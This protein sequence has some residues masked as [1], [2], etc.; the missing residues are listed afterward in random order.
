MSNTAVALMMMPIAMAVVHR[1]GQS[2]PGQAAERLSTALV[3]A[4]AFGASIGGIGT[5]VGSPPN[6]IFMEQYAKAFPNGPAIT[7]LSWTLLCTPL[8][9]VLL[10]LAWAS[11]YFPL[12]RGSELRGGAL[13]LSEDEHRLPRISGEEVK[14]LLV[15]VGAVL[16]WLFRSP[17]HL[18]TFTVPGWGSWFTGRGTASLVDDGTVAV[19]ATILLFI[20]PAGAKAGGGPLLRW[21]D[22]ERLPWGTMLL[23][24]GGFALAEGLQSSGLSAWI[25][26][27]LA[28][29]ASLPPLL[30]LV[31][32]Y[33]ST[34]AFG[35]LASNTAV[36]QVLLPIAASISETAR[37]SPALL[38][39][40][41]AIAASLDFLLPAATP[42]NAIAV[43]TGKVSPRQLLMYGL[44]IEIVSAFVTAAAMFWLAPY[45]LA[46]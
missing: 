45:V 23:F 7:F 22:L 10:L 20:L 5:P 25:G 33:M 12:G 38:M 46:L 24:G 36:A 39:I 42:P 41:V 2:K 37:L 1:L 19:F 4:V 18:G 29:L 16:C 14:V 30:M 21:K 8:M 9:L 26:T 17:L 32:V 28:A 13:A 6:L 34:S 15:F 27:Q 44:F 35:E 43:A 40:P 31:A 11:L 3:L